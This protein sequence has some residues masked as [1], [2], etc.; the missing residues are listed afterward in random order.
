MGRSSGR[1]DLG[2]GTR[3]VSCLREGAMDDFF[4][5][6][7]RRH[8]SRSTTLR[9]AGELDIATTPHLEAALTDLSGTVLID[10][11]ELSFIDASGIRALVAASTRL[12]IQLAN[13]TPFVGRVFEITGTETFLLPSLSP[14]ER[15][16]LLRSRARFAMKAARNATENARR[17]GQVLQPDADDCTAR[18]VHEQSS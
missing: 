13:V 8:S 6:E 17:L 7:V 1:T 4:S 11:A 2:G 14:V 15:A 16:R 5:V 9:V 10:C 12:H 18:D 3:R